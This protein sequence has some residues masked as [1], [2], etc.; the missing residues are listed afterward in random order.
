MGIGGACL[1][2]YWYTIKM[3]L[4]RYLVNQTATY[5][6]MLY[7]NRTGVSE[8]IEVNESNESNECM[9]CHYWNFLDCNDKYEPEVYDDCHDISMMAY[10]LENIVILNIKGIDYICVI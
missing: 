8:G 2:F 6:T 5:V 9:I 3:V 10:E 7:C 1:Y 4:K